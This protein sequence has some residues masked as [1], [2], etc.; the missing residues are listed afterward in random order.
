MS[1]LEMMFN[2]RVTGISMIEKC[3]SY[4]KRPACQKKGNFKNVVCLLEKSVK[5]K[6]WQSACLAKSM[7][8]VANIPKMFAW[9]T[10]ILTEKIARYL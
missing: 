3:D 2:P 8:N 7:T 6:T 4:D 10:E 1:I 5:W 9:E